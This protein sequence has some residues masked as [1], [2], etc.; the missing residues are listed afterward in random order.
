[1][2]DPF[3][4]FVEEMA[5]LI[6]PRGRHR[7]K[8]GAAR[9]RRVRVG[10]ADQRARRIRPHRLRGRRVPVLGG[11][12]ALG[13]DPQGARAGRTDLTSTAHSWRQQVGIV[14][15]AVKHDVT[16]ARPIERSEA[17]DG[18]PRVATMT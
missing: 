18:K 6:G 12:G 5:R 15:A 10:D 11:A 16:G 14:Q 9:G 8:P 3:K 2:S 4:E 1:M 17:D 7:G 13:D